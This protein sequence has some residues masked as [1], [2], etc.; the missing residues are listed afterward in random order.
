MKRERSMT[1]ML[2][3][4]KRIL[5]ATANRTPQ[6]DDMDELLMLAE[7]EVTLENALQTVIDGLRRDGITWKSIGEVMGTTG[8]AA[9]MRWGEQNAAARRARLAKVEQRQRAYRDMLRAEAA[10]QKA[11]RGRRSK[12]EPD[13]AA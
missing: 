4:A 8:Q 9:N 13:E 5:N 12:R 2:G 1:D 11:S 6:G 3:A 7:I 10:A